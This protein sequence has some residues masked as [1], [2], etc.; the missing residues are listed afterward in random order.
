MRKMRR[1]NQKTRRK[2]REENIKEEEGEKR[3]KRNR[4]RVVRAQEM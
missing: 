3:W 2:E 1:I 4:L